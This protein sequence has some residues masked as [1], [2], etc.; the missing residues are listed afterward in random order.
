MGW[1]D[2]AL[3]GELEGVERHDQL[4]RKHCLNQNLSIVLSTTLPPPKQALP[5]AIGTHSGPEILHARAEHANKPGESLTEATTMGPHLM[6][7]PA[8]LSVIAKYIKAPYA[9]SEQYTQ[10]V[11]ASSPSPAP[12]FELLPSSLLGP[13]SSFSGPGSR[14]ASDFKTPL[15]IAQWRSRAAPLSGVTLQFVL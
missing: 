13:C 2:L 8:K 4:H 5:S 9:F 3:L 14:F 12:A 1:T 6:N 15:R 10:S 7:A 11:S